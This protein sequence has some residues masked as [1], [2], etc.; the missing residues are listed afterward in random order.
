MPWLDVLV[1]NGVFPKFFF[2]ID[3]FVENRL[4]PAFLANTTIK[5]V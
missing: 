4:S 2:F 3:A 1:F 5:V